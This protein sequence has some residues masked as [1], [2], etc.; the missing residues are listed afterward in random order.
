MKL[1]AAVKKYEATFQKGLFYWAEPIDG[2][3]CWHV[4]GQ[5][6]GYPGTEAHDDWFAHKKDADEI[7]RQ[8]AA[9]E[10]P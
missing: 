9:G 6:T 8:M 10:K 3:K 7:A 2:G 1:K 5:M 4:V